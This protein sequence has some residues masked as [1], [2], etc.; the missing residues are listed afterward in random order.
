[1]LFLNTTLK[2]EGIIHVG[3]MDLILMVKDHFSDQ[4]L[5]VNII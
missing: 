5:N 2:Q 1:M 3:L 4:V